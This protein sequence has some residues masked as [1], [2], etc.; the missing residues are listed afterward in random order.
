MLLYSELKRNSPSET[1]Y[2]PNTKLLGDDCYTLEMFLAWAAASEILGVGCQGPTVCCWQLIM[3]SKLQQQR[4]RAT[5]ESINELEAE[6]A[7]I[8]RL[9]RAIGNKNTELVEAQ[10]YQQP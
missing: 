6:E 9:L 4:L 7:V 2:G 1:L 5:N 10:R 3:A 8:T